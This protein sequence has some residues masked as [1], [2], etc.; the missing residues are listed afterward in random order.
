MAYVQRAENG[1]RRIGIGAQDDQRVVPFERPDQGRQG[2][3]PIALARLIE[4]EIIPRLLMAHQSAARA[5]AA[6]PAAGGI[7]ASEVVGFAKLVLAE[8]LDVLRQNAEDFVARGIEVDALYFDLFSPAAKLLGSMWE[9]DLCSVNDVT[10]GL[11]RLQQLVYEFSDRIRPDDSGAGRTAL[12]AL[13]P[14][15]PAFVRPGPGRRVLPS[16]RLAHGLRTRCQRAR[17]DRYGQGRVIRPD[18]FLDGG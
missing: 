15:R 6:T 10:V 12:F 17:S 9:E 14:G 16:R 13:T 18:R 3:S 1:S 8:E 5:N 2:L 7:S 4:G 11:C